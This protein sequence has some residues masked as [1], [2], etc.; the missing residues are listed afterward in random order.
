MSSSLSS[1]QLLHLPS[2]SAAA[3]IWHFNAPIVMLMVFGIQNNFLFVPRCH[4]ALIEEWYLSLLPTR[5]WV[6]L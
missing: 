6:F 3:A 4:S 1:P 2:L 5:T